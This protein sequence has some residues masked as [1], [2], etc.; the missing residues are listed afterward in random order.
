MGVVELSKENLNKTGFPR[1]RYHAWNTTCVQTPP[2]DGTVILEGPIYASVNKIITFNLTEKVE[3]ILKLTI[4][5]F[6]H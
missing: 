3:T 2:E 6:S 4:L 1:M 5:C